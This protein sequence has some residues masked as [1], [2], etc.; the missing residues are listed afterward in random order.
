MSVTRQADRQTGRGRTL[1]SVSRRPSTPLKEV[2]KEEKQLIKEPWSNYGPRFNLRRL[3]DVWESLEED[4]GAPGDPALLNL[5]A[6]PSACP[7]I[8]PSSPELSSSL[9]PP[10]PVSL[11]H[12]A[13][14]CHYSR[15]VFCSAD[16]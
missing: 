16:R 8:T 6:W 1:S 4:D 13:E 10:P 2:V 5:A 15:Q 14:V 9:C 3:F 7:C 12:L 11:F